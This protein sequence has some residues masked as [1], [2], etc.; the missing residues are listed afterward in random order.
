MFIKV[1]VLEAWNK[2]L[3]E[4]G[5]ILAPGMKN[6]KRI[7]GKSGQ[8]RIDWGGMASPCSNTRE[9]QYYPGCRRHC[10]ATFPE[11]EWNDNLQWAIPLP[12]YEVDGKVIL[13][14]KFVPDEAPVLPTGWLYQLK[15]TG[16]WITEVSLFESF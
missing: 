1:T 3:W 14:R 4:Y 6:I 13:A 10:L 8:L 9:I 15:R 2:R 16:Q 5:K 11:L 12:A 7:Y